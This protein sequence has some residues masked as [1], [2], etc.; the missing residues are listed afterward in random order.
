ML[1]KE[2]IKFWSWSYSKRLYCSHFGF[3]LHYI[4]YNLFSLTL[5]S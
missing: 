5:V 3:P 2:L 1:E 4:A